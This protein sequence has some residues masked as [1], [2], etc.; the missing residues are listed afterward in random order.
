MSLAAVP[1]YLI[2][3]RLRLGTGTALA[4]A[5]LAVAGP[6]LLFVGTILSEP[7]AYPL[8]LGAFAAGLALLERPTPR[9]QAAFLV[10]AGLAAF[11]RVQFA[12]LPVC[13]LVAAVVAGLRE[14]RLRRVL[15]EQRLLLGISG[16]G[17]RRGSPSS[18]RTGSATTSASRP[19][20][21]AS[22]RCK[23]R[24][25]TSSCCCSRPAARSRRVP[26]SAPRW[27]SRSRGRTRSLRSAL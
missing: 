1:V 6:Q 22:R 24:A 18:R 15:R 16:S 14:R 23:S 13:V 7:Y 21:R 11:T 5:A 25:P 10:L 2:A 3:R 12:V 4:L 26:S 20:A 19:R 9:V 8:V 17:S 27:R